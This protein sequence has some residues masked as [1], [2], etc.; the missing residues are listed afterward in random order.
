MLFIHAFYMFYLSIN[1][2]MESSQIYPWLQTPVFPLTLYKLVTRSVCH[3]TMMK[4]DCL[5]KCWLLN[6]WI[7]APRVWG[8]P[9]IF[10]LDLWTNTHSHTTAKSSLTIGMVQWGETESWF[11]AQVVI[12]KDHRRRQVA[13]SRGRQKVIHRGSKKATVQ[14]WKRLVTSS[15]RSGNR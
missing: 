1:Q 2:P 8:S 12:V 11:Q 3:Y 4:T 13:G 5:S 10:Q 14:A 7:W 15:G 6:D 9:F